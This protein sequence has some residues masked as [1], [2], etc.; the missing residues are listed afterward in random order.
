M[1]VLGIDPATGA[2]S[3]TG[4]AAFDSS[5]MSILFTREITT[6]QRDN[7][8]RKLAKLSLEVSGVYDEIADRSDVVVGCESFVMVGK[9]GQL[10]Q[11]LIGSYISRIPLAW[12]FEQVSNTSMKRVVSGSGEGDKLDVAL[13][14][15]FFFRN[16]PV[17]KSYIQALIKDQRWDRTDAVGIA[18]AAFIQCGLLIGDKSDAALINSFCSSTPELKAHVA[19]RRLELNIPKVDKVRRRGK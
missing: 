6:S 16:S 7:E 1:I 4:A 11:R 14:C 13:G 10:L 19:A 15:E 2:S 8:H 18:V 3:P 17:A 9:T 12:H 5:D